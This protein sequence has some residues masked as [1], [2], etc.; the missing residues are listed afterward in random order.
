LPLDKNFNST[1]TTRQTPTSDQSLSIPTPT[2]TSRTNKI[3]VFPSVESLSHSGNENPMDSATEASDTSQN[4][5]PKNLTIQFMDSPNSVCSQDEQLNYS[6]IKSYIDQ[7]QSK[8]TQELGPTM[9]KTGVKYQAA[10]P[11]RF[12]ILGTLNSS[13]STDLNGSNLKKSLSDSNLCKYALRSSYSK[14]DS[15]AF[16]QQPRSEMRDSCIISGFGNGF[17][18]RAYSTHLHKTSFR[19]ELHSTQSVFMGSSQTVLP[20]KNDPFDSKNLF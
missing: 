11:T 20:N 3:F 5:K 10:A 14:Q 15:I 12:S 1:Q 17:D 16:E 4:L 13:P 9:R 2:Q 19:R 7:K 18:E 8:V 6:K